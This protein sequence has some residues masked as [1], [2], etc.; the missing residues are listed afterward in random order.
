M[1][2]DKIM[3]ER[4]KTHTV[5][6]D[7]DNSAVSTLETFLKSFGKINTNFAARDKWPNTDGTFEFVPNPDLSRI[8]EQSF[9]VQI[10]GTHYYRDSWLCRSFLPY[11]Q[12]IFP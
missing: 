7:L 2:N 5:H 8:P 9:F 10:K 1:N 6:S 12:Y 3:K 4:I 11:Q